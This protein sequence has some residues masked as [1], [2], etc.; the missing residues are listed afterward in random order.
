[1]NKKI[2]KVLIFYA[3]LSFVA[4]F[5][6]PITPIYLNDI[7]FEKSL[8][9]LL[10]SFMA[11]GLAISAPIAGRLLDKYGSRY[12][13]VSGLIIYSI[14]QTMFGTFTT[15]IPLVSVRI[16]A[17]MGVSLVFPVLIS[18]VAKV[19]DEATRTRTLGI[20]FAIGLLFVSIGYQFGGWLNNFVEARM[21]F[22]IQAVL[23]LM[24]AVASL[25]LD[26]TYVHVESKMKFDLR[27]LD[28]NAYTY[29]FVFFLFHFATQAVTRF[30]DV[31]IIDLGYSAQELGTLVLVTGMMGIVANFILLP[32]LHKILPDRYFLASILFVSSISL[33]LSFHIFESLW[34][35]LY[36]FFLVFALAKSM[37]DPVHNSLISKI[38]NDHQGQLIGLSESAKMMGM[39]MGPLLGGII[40]AYNPIMLFTISSGILLSGVI[41][42][43][44]FSGKRI[45]M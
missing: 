2:V 11:L 6:H 4:N 31:Y 3:A 43:R 20:Q 1:M 36:T 27:H 24:L 45:S 26:N 33:Y 30:L 14:A 34:L 7:G 25:L 29:L 19:S 12:L 35:G 16:L 21:F 40:Y 10:F 5:Q 18:Y 17:G 41:V 44:I 22:Y 28:R 32:L 38:S 39:F 23:L 15:I 13:L 37:Y 9:G 8:Y 42:W